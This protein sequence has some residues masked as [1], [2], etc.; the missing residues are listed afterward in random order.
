MKSIPKLKSQGGWIGAAIGA[1]AALLGSRS[2][3]RADKRY[4]E[5]GFENSQAGMR[6]GNQLDM[7]NQMSMFDFKMNRAR[8]AGLTAVEAFGSPVAGSGGGTTG[9]GNTLGNAANQSAMAAAERS[10]DRH[11][12][13]QHELINA[14]TQLQQTKMQTDAQKEVASMQTGATERGQDIQKAIADGRLALDR[15]SYNINLRTAAANIGKTEQETRKLINEVATSEKDFVV[16]MKQLSMGADNMLVE[17]FQR[18]HNI[19]LSDPKSFTKLPVQK[20]QS[21]LSAMIALS[22]SSFKEV[23]GLSSAGSNVLEDVTNLGSNIKELVSPSEGIQHTPGAKAA[24]MG[25]KK[26]PR[27]RYYR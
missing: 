10:K 8:H 14:G 9:S 3:R 27:G 13:L 2:Q 15:D 1:G 24:I 12:A 18:H 26:S 5:Q 25:R 21:L 7:Q 4:Q 23:S 16:Y 20:R 22:S 6:L 19:N 17:Y 11:T